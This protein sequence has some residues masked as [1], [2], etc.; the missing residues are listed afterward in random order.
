[1]GQYVL[2]AA[3]RSS[4]VDGEAELVLLL[5]ENGDPKDGRVVNINASRVDGVVSSQYLSSI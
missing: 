2:D 1:M 4:N 5:C 3:I